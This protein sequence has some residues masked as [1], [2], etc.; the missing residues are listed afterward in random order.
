[1]GTAKMPFSPHFRHVRNIRLGY[2][3]R[4]PLGLRTLAGR[5]SVVSL[6]EALCRAVIIPPRG[7]IFI[8]AAKDRFGGLFVLLIRGMDA[9]DNLWL[10][11]SLYG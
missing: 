5:Q 7:K 1:M 9:E 8:T 11:F 10:F 6:P 3:A 4:T 2:A